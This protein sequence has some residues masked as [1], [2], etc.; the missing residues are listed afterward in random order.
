M[1]HSDGSL[2]IVSVYSNF[3]NAISNFLERW[4]NKKWKKV[5]KP[6]YFEN[7]TE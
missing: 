4:N 3:L 1:Y 5:R 7:L 6:T 2:K